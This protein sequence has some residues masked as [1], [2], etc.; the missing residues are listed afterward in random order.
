MSI[1]YCRAGGVIK[2]IHEGQKEISMLKKA[3]KEKDEQLT[4]ERQKVA[5]LASELELQAKHQ[6]AY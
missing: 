4:I 6:G 2:K 5:G 1:S 3:N